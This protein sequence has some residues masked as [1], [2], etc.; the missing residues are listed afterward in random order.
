MTEDSAAVG[1]GRQGL[2]ILV[3]DDNRDAADSLVVLLGLLGYEA[4][5]T[6]GGPEALRLAGEFR[7]DCLF[8]D[9][10][11]PGMDGYEVARRV[12]EQPGLERARLVALSA[13]SDEGHRRRAAL[14]GFDHQLTKPADPGEL[15]RLLTMMQ[16]VLRLAEKTEELARQNVALAS[17]TRELLREVKEDVAGVKEEVRELKQEIREALAEGKPPDGTS[18]APA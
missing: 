1:Q 15:R 11:M 10:R 3:V 17:Q 12:R 18:D 14:A 13:F 2:R 8:L 6:Y 9:I 16:E 4:R 5:G 7:P